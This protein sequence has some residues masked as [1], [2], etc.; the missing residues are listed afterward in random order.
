MAYGVMGYIVI[1]Y[2][3]MVDIVTQDSAAERQ[4]A[5]HGGQFCP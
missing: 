3:V 2:L 5:V 4:W 1:A